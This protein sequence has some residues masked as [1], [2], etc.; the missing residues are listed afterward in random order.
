MKYI[1][2]LL[3][4]INVNGEE[5]TNE[6]KTICGGNPVT[7]GECGMNCRFKYDH[8]DKKLTI[9]GDAIDDYESSRYVPW[10]HKMSTMESVVMEN[11]ASIG[12]KA[13]NNLKSIK[14]FEYK[15]IEEPDCQSDF[16]TTTEIEVVDV[17]FGY[18]GS[19]FC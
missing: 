14:T 11:I 16:S 5:T 6:K 18:Q 2:L 13:F 17:S 12:K 19:S 9:E 3:I 4:M 7:N 1:L 8:V 10:Y 15:G